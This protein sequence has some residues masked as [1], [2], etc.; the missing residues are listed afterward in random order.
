MK[1]WAWLFSLCWAGSAWAADAPLPLPPFGQALFSAER[2]EEVAAAP[3]PSQHVARGDSIQLRLW[4]AVKSDERATVDGKGFIYVP[5][6]G[7]VKVEGVPSGK[8]S[9]AIREQLRPVFKEDIFVYASLDQQRG[10]PVLVTGAAGK[11]GQYWGGADD[12]LVVFLQKAGGILPEQGSYRDIRLVRGGREAQRFDLYPFLQQG[13][14][15]GVQW[16]PGDTLVVGALKTHVS[17]SGA[18][19]NAYRFEFTGAAPTGAELLPYA[20]PQ[21]EAT[22]VIIT[23]FRGGRPYSHTLPLPEF[24][25]ATLQNGDDVYFYGGRQRD[26]IAIT[27]EGPL[28]DN[29]RLVVPAGSTLEDVLDQI[30]VDPQAS[31]AAAIYL[32]RPGVAR[33]QKEAIDAALYRL[34]QSVLTAPAASDAEA[35]IRAKEAELIRQFVQKAQA[36]VPDGRIVISRGQQRLNLALEDRDVIVI[37]RRTDVVYIEGEVMLPHAVVAQKGRSAGDYIR[38]A[39]GFT[40]RAERGEY[41]VLHPNGEAVRSASPDIRPGD[42]LFILPKVDTKSLQATKDIVQILYEIAVGAGVLLSI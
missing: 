9:E 30:A 3:S 42:R 17:A 23:G 41:M 40:E 6:V 27:V 14:L 24:S 26:R 10:V 36:I 34:E 32:K 35:G 13:L 37:P 39:G 8:L 11:P 5:D 28:E 15:P 38:M 29:P 16:L 1:K 7:P 18:I 20:A 19:R 21:P 4:G 22:H 25:A 12:S 31:D 2:V 33:M